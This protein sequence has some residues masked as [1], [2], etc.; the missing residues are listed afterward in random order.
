[1]DGWANIRLFGKPGSVYDFSSLDYNQTVAQCRE[2]E[3]SQKSRGKKVN[4]KVMN[5]IEGCVS[6]RET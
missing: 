3:A 2:L 1:M 5:M 6:Q 4:T